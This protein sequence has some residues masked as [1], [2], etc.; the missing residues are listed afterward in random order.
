MTKND[1]PYSFVLMMFCMDL[2]G[3][4]YT[5]EAMNGTGIVILA[6][7]RKC[8]VRSTLLLFFNSLCINK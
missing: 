8:C 3:K 1:K 7:L 4:N 6:F 2:T 5:G